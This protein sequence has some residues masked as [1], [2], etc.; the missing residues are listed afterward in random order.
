[1]GDCQTRGQ[2]LALLV[3]QMDQ[4]EKVEGT[5]GYGASRALADQFC[6][7]VKQTLR[8][9]DELLQVGDRKFWVILPGSKNEGH[10]VLAANKFSRLA[11][12]PFLVGDH[13][14]KLDC[15]IGIAIFPDHATEPE[16][17]VRRAD[18]ALA[19]ARE[20]RVSHRVYSID[21]TQ[22]MASLWEVEN[23]L[24]RAL[25]ESEFELYY[26]PK[27]DLKTFRPCGAEALLRWNNPTRGFLT[28]DAF[29]PVAD[30][31]GKLDAV[32]WFVLD[33]A[34]RQR[35]EWT[36]RWGELP[37]SVNVPPVV[38]D[39]GHLIEYIKGSMRIWGAQTNNLTL[40]V[41]EEGVVKNPGRSFAALAQLRK[42]G[43]KISIDDFGTGYSS[44]TYFKE[45]PAD[46]LKIDKSFMRNLVED[47]GNQHIVRA[48]IDLA[49]TFNYQVVAEG[50]ER[51][52][53]LQVLL[54]M[55]CDIV[56][57]FLFSRP[58]PQREFMEWLQDY[59]VR[60]LATIRTDPNR[61]NATG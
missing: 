55:N 29:L 14:V 47:K 43:I 8:D 6:A 21:S 49:H 2:M 11:K 27:I 58:Q 57:G 40:E 56:Q 34:Q 7:R 9:D 17:L 59:K 45:M 1:M 3:V 52:D 31:A 12:G 42:E 38:L 61:A 19:N 25:E 16:E 46:E 54:G 23:E 13:T 30:R 5:L 53:V 60:D 4:L 51:E 26:Q 15:T 41:T 18:L 36:D 28:P 10:A 44:M 39:S 50:V 35:C 32:T 22:Q 37:V 24:D 20:D 48:I 33:A